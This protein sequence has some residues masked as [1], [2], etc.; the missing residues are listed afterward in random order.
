MLAFF[1]TVTAGIMPIVFLGIARA[2]RRRVRRFQREGT[3]TVAEILD[4]QPVKIA[5]DEHLSQV[6][7]Q[8]EAGGTMHRD[9]DLVLPMFA[10]RWRAGDRVHVLY[11][12][13]LG[14]DSIIV[15]TS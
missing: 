2:R 9:T 13:A 5:F 14:Y 3:P 7:Y 8:F 4:I 11:L 6:S 1:S 15:S 10:N 12:P